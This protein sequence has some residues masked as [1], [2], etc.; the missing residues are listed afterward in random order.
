M[1]EHTREEMEGFIDWEQY[2]RESNTRILNEWIM[3]GG[4]DNPFW[5]RTNG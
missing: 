3:W 2:E 5:L 1:K 4:E